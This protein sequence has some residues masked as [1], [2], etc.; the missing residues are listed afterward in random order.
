M[1]PVAPHPSTALARD[2][3]RRYLAEWGGAVLRAPRAGAAGAEEEPDPVARVVYVDAFGYSGGK[4]LLTGPAREGGGAESPLLGVEALEVLEERA[5][6]RRLPLRTGAVLVEEDPAHVEA[7]RAGLGDRGL[8]PRLRSGE[9]TLLHAPFAEAAGEAARALEGAEHALCFLDPSAPGKLPLAAV[10]ALAATGADLLLAFPHAELRTQAR[11][12]TVPLA[13]LP[14]HARRGADGYAALL[15]DARHEWLHLWREAEREEGEEA[16]ELRLAERYAARLA[17][18]GRVVKRVSLRVAEEPAERLHLF[19]LTPDPARA[20][21]L[22]RLLREAR[23]DDRLLP[24]GSLRLRVVE[25]P[26]E[27][28]ALEL[29][30]PREAGAVPLPGGEGA[31][32]ADLPLAARTLAE[33]FR[34]RTV[35]YREVLLSL[36]TTDLDPEEARRAMGVLKRSGE[37]L[38]RSLADPEAAVAFPSTPVPPKRRRRGAAD[39]PGLLALLDPPAEG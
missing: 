22:N 25:E 24:D 4:R 16:A 15:D 37:A 2:L 8:G 38:Y 17:E 33:R 39:P 35:A 31:R 28:E 12:R 26:P 19:L 14:P 36:V 21:V 6:E 20:L 11:Y 32:G 1:S 18:T 7:L 29:F 5:R 30:S 10:R 27:A 23:V 9:I 3:L 34:G 13:D